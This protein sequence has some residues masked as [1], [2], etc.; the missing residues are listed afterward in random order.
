MDQSFP[1]EVD[2][3]R[4]EVIIYGEAVGY[5][6][7]YGSGQDDIDD[8][9]EIVEP[10]EPMTTYASFPFNEI[11]Q[12]L[13]VQEHLIKDIFQN[14]TDYHLEVYNPSDYNI[15]CSVYVEYYDRSGNVVDTA[16]LDREIE[17]GGI[18]VLHDWD[19]DFDKKIVR[20]EL[21]Y[22]VSQCVEY[23][24]PVQAKLDYQVQR[25]SFGYLVTVTNNSSHVV[26]K[27]MVD[28]LFLRNE[29]VMD[30]SS[31]A[32]NTASGDSTIRPGEK[33]TCVLVPFGD[34]DRYDDCRIYVNG[35]Y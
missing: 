9:Q 12:G 15:V 23:N 10:D 7:K 26:D 31:E 28:C 27:I 24:R 32:V 1:E 4:F 20:T 2:Y 30:Y 8:T 25:L 11:I 18:T 33:G 3:D 21:S 5:A 13:I 19:L 34:F 35:L 29:K 17:A 22:S 6:P 16:I 14:A